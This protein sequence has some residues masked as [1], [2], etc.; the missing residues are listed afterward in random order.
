M[1]GKPKVT[2]NYENTNL[3]WDLL[4][5][6]ADA[7]IQMAQDTDILRAAAMHVGECTPELNALPGQLQ[8]LFHYY[9]DLANKNIPE[10]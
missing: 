6:I 4:A 10:D 2:L 1:I 5:S 3:K 8:A 9:H 7:C